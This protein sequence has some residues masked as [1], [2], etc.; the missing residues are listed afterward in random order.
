MASW[1]RR[2]LLLVLT[3]GSVLTGIGLGFIMRSFNLTPQ[4]IV[5]VSFPGEMLMHML[6]LMILPL[7]ISSLISGKH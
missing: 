5:L 7:I 4:S 6:K 1:L 3:I 2:N